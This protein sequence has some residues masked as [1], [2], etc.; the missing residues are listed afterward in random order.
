MLASNSC[1]A[2]TS[3]TSN[4]IYGHAPYLTLDGGH[5]RVKDTNGLL[6]ITLSNGIRF[7][8]VTN[9]STASNPIELPNL[10]ET[11]ADVQMFIPLDTDSIELNSL[12]GSPYN[13]WGDDDGDG[14]GSDG[15]WAS[16]SLSL[17]IANN[18]NQTVARNARLDIC[19]APYKLILTSTGG[20]LATRYGF[21]KS[22]NF[23]ASTVTYYISP[24][25]TSLICFAKPVLQYGV[26]YNGI[27][28]FRGP[29]KMWNEK[30]GFI[31][32]SIDPSTYGLNFP[33]TGANNLYFDLKISV[34]D[35]D[36]LTWASVTH[37]GITATVKPTPGDSSGKSFRVTLTGPVATPD[38]W[39][40][41]EPGEIFKPHLPQQFELK[42]INGSGNTVAKYGFELKQWFVNRG[43]NNRY[44]RSNTSSWCNKIGYRLS[45]IKDLTNASCRGL[46]ENPLSTCQGITNNALFLSTNNY[47]QRI[48]GA[49]FFSEWGDIDLYDIDAPP[50]TPK[51]NF[52]DHGYNYYWSGD[53]IDGIPVVVNSANGNIHKDSSIDRL[54][55]VCVTP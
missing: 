15:V 28:D 3:V 19:N 37:S 9:D 52:R 18:N 49:G 42:A 10:G 53:S 44:D 39:D 1:Q 45:V 6:G 22:S 13:Y 41:S 5:T 2:L 27:I 55:A 24:K 29:N 4:F 43:D 54:F 38:Q 20:T 51:T 48:I 23:N 26:L 21:P 7:T 47:Y 14:Q 11:L 36:T 8:P 12:I 32:Q 34:S 30:E 25:A 31:L 50:G 16:G 46:S 33:N 35:S 40:S 17:T